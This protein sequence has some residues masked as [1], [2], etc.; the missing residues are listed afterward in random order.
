MTYTILDTGTATAVVIPKSTVTGNNVD[1]NCSLDYTSEVYD[2]T[3]NEWVELT[4]A[5]VTSTYTFIK[6]GTLSD[7][8]TTNT[9]SI[10]TTAHATWGGKT[11]LMR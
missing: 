3:K 2:E 6:G 9:F 4:A 7:A 10:E 11:I 1:A 8:K 5:L